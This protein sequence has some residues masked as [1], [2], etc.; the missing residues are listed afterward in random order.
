MILLYLLKAYKM[1]Q[2]SNVQRQ[3]KIESIPSEQWTWEKKRYYFITLFII[4]FSPSFALTLILL[5]L[6]Y[7]KRMHIE[8]SKNHI[9]YIIHCFLFFIHWT[10]CCKVC[11]FLSGCKNKVLSVDRDMDF[12]QLPFSLMREK[13]FWEYFSF[14]IQ[15]LPSQNSN[16]VPTCEKQSENCNLWWL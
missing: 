13:L 6:S 9:S 3:W 10:N 1:I 7:N 2:Y 11:I 4:D 16:I 15:K 8:S 14:N 12:F 5:P